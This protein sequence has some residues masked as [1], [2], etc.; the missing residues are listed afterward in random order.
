MR[1]QRGGET[2]AETQVPRDGLEVGEGGRSETKRRGETGSER[3]REMETET[4]TDRPGK[5]RHR[6]RETKI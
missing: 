5:E 4:Q 6:D 2:K 1:V 3:E